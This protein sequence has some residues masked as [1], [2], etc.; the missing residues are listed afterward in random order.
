MSTAKIPVIIDTDP[1]VDDI[2]ALLLAL[3]SPEIEVLA[4]IISFGNTDAEASY[5]NVLK[6]YQ[7]IHRQLEQFPQDAY[8][9]VNFSQERKT[10]LAVGE[11]GPL[12]GALHSAKYF[13]GR[14][15]LGGITQSHPD[16][17]V[18][19]NHPSQHPQLELSSKSGVE[20]ALN[21]IK[22]EPERTISYI[23]L[24][25]LTNL[26]KILRLDREAVRD[27]IGRVVCMGGALD[28]PGNHNPVSEFNV[29]A[30]PF[31]VKELLTPDDLEQGLPLNRFL[32]LP[33]D[34]TTPHEIRFPY[35]KEMV[36]PAFE[37]TAFP[38][39]PEGKPPI[40]HFTSS[41]FERTREVMRQFGKDAME[42]HDIAAVW[43]A[44]ENPPVRDE[45]PDPA[46]LPVLQQGWKAMRRKFGV[47]RLG[48]LTRGM[49][50]IDRREDPSAYAPG[51]NRAKVQAELDRLNFQHSGVYE[52]TAVPAEVEVET[53]PVFKDRS[54]VHAQVSTGAT[55]TDTL[56]RPSDGQMNGVAGGVPC[57]TRTP[58]SAALVKLLLERVWGVRS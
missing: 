29:F 9:Y 31:A 32:L 18:D 58:G 17:N 56:D 1:G 40:V 26:A 34:I 19:D 23:A 48:E 7:A 15:G 54:H 50:V 10:I 53:P 30:D 46:A 8:R 39:Q 49:F 52:S 13:H 45:D 6:T 47:E 42:L 36:D 2:L 41:F 44:I 20:V 4:I 33:L 22:S 25:P 24:G 12:E 51:A 38:S 11:D 43:C 55:A 5:V 27:R 35:Y 16:L 57:I 3:A 37:S 14:D 21:L 28:V